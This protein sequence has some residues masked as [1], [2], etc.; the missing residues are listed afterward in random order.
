MIV[1]TLD[2]VT[3]EAGVLSIPRDLWVPIPGY[4]EGRINTAHAIGDAY[5]H[6]GGGTALAV[7]TVEY[8]LGIEID[9]FV[10]VNFQGFV[11]LVDA[12]GGIEMEVPET[13]DDPQYPIT[14]M[15]TTHS[16]SR[17]GRTTLTG[18]WRSNTRGRATPPAGISTAPGG[19][20]R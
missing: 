19:S 8:N 2:P 4:T 11:Q 20:S 14:T 5:D 10:R 15:A 1:G 3:M 9:Y 18:R 6:P 7:E 17:P 12:I 16:T 13:I